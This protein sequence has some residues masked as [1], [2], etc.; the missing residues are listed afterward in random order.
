MIFLKGFRQVFDMLRVYQMFLKVSFCSGDKKVQFSSTLDIN[1]LKKEI[2]EPY[3][4]FFSLGNVINLF[5]ILLL[6]QGVL[7]F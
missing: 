7:I 5:K 1:C 3:R 2:R 4:L 6:N